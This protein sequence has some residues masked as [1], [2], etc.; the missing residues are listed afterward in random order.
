MGSEVLSPKS[1][2]V[3]PCNLSRRKHG[4]WDFSTSHGSQVLS[5]KHV[6][7]AYMAILFGGEAWDFVL[8]VGSSKKLEPTL[9]T[10]PMNIFA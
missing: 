8:R 4:S 3:N 9:S 10:T 7:D 1:L 5:P 6:M 2:E